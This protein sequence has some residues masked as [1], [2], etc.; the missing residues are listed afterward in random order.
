[1]IN[2]DFESIRGLERVSFKIT[3][4]KIEASTPWGM[5]HSLQSIS[6]IYYKNRLLL[7]LSSA[8]ANG[9]QPER[10]FITSD[11][12]PINGTIIR[13]R[14]VDAR[15]PRNLLSLG[16]CGSIISMW[17]STETLTISAILEYTSKA[18]LHFRQNNMPHLHFNT[19][20]LLLSEWPRIEW[21]KIIGEIDREILDKS[22]IRSSK[23]RETTNAW[24]NSALNAIKSFDRIYPGLAKL[25]CIMRGDTPIIHQEMMPQKW[26]PYYTKFFDVLTSSRRPVCGF[27]DKN[28]IIFFGFDNIF[29]R[30]A[31]R[32]TL[33]IQKITHSSPTTFFGEAL[34]IFSD[35]F[36]DTPK[37]NVLLEQEKVELRKKENDLKFQEER[38]EL[39]NEHLRL[40][41]EILKEELR[42]ARERVQILK[43]FRNHVD[44]GLSGLHAEDVNA[45]SKAI[46][47]IEN[48]YIRSSMRL[49]FIKNSISAYRSMGNS[50][51][52]I[53]KPMKHID[54]E[55]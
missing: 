37:R 45:I 24:R 48:E 26:F 10:I 34:Q 32:A 53:S 29:P 5:Q 50:I 25:S 17:P 1:M 6:S 2:F 14:V 4:M 44:I 46:D 54:E 42:M 47:G 3:D 8:I 20:Q 52:A 55:V 51:I 21:R 9:I 41:N 23:F 36:L 43:S 39:T 13:D 33:D 7:S 49:Q 28:K 30:T 27:F 16:R 38:N 18:S 11:P 19:L 40:K 12:F 31:S 22:N 15:D 35:A